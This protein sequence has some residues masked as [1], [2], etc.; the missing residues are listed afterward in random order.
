MAVDQLCR[1]AKD[2]PDDMVRSSAVA[3]LRELRDPRAFDAFVAALRAYQPA[4]ARGLY[5]LGDVR[6]LRPLVQALAK[7]HGYYQLDV[8]MKEALIEA[9]GDFEQDVDEVWTALVAR[10][11]D[12]SDHVTECAAIACQQLRPGCREGLD[13][14][15]QKMERI[16]RVPRLVERNTVPMLE[17]LDRATRRQP[18]RDSAAASEILAAMKRLHAR[19]RPPARDRLL[20]SIETWSRWLVN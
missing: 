6:A 13:K 20:V 19:I 4:A 11:R 16:P 1:A 14:I 10:L 9:L 17:R 15:A 8:M 18:P 12:R 3:A 5:E 7:D 2:D